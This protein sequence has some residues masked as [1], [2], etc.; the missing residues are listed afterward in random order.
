MQFTPEQI[1]EKR[2]LKEQVFTAVMDLQKSQAKRIYAHFYLVI[3]VT[4][5][6][7]TEGVSKSCVSESISYGIKNLSKN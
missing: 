3:S 7:V 4:E 6:A 1:L 5:I 2:K